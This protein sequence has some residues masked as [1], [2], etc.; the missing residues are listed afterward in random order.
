MVVSNRQYRICLQHFA[1]IY[2]VV[3]QPANNVNVY[4]H[5]A[6][7]RWCPQK[8]HS[9]MTRTAGVS[10]PFISFVQSHI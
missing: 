5:H 10:R 6:A 8:V 7:T 1:Y 2:P 4:G 3:A 9:S